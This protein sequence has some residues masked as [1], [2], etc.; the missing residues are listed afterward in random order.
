MLLPTAYNILQVHSA[1]ARVPRGRRPVRKMEF[2]S[3][4]DLGT[5]P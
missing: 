1:G 5:P 3:A 2:L 4:H